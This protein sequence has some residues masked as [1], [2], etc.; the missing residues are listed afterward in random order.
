MSDRSTYPPKRQVEAEIIPPGEPVHL[1]RPREKSI[2]VSAGTHSRE[3]H[4]RKLGP[5]GIIVAALAA[6]LAIAIVLAIVVSVLLIW[7][8][9]V[10]LILA[11]LIIT[12][13]LR[14]WRR[15]D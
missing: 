2:W 5:V 12:G 7:I 15:P 13:V 3:I 6:G 9:I 4:F 11:G 14:A 10:G 1:R 8:P